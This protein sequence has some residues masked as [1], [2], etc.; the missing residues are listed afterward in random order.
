MV[1]VAQLAGPMWLVGGQTVEVPAGVAPAVFLIGFLEAD[2]AELGERELVV[3]STGQPSFTLTLGVDGSVTTTALT[4][5]R[6][7]EWLRPA[8]DCAEAPVVDEQATRAGWTLYGLHHGSG[9]STWAELLDSTEIANPD[10][11]SGRL[12]L[13]ARTTLR[14]VEEAKQLTY[15]AGAVLM[16]ADAPGNVPADVRRGIKVLSGAAPIVHVPWVPPLRGMLTVS[17]NPAMARVAAKIA[18]AVRGSWKEST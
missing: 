11:A 16:V 12:L 2:S 9:A 8:R 15:R 3:Q 1:T 14:G 10:A 17:Q 7:L 13:V 4:D 18:A 6:I 5:P